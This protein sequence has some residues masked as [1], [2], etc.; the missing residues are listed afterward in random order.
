MGVKKYEFCADELIILRE[1]LADYKQHINPPADASE[2]RK[3]N[4][5]ICKALLEQIANDIRL[6][7]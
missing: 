1:A 5:A 3:R 7:R 4:Y 2:Q 6:L